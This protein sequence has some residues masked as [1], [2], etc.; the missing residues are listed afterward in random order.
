LW[1]HTKDG[2]VLVRTTEYSLPA[3]LN[4][5]IELIQP[6]TTFNR[7]KRQR[8]T[9]RFSPVPETSTSL[10]PDANITVPS[11][12][13]TVNASC[14]TTMTVSCIKQLYNAVHYVPHAMNKNGIAVTGYL[15]QFAN[16]DDLQR[17]YAAQ[18]PAAVNTSFDVVLIDGAHRIPS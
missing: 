18:V 11:Y 7:A 6:T 2:E 14:V 3:Y 5:H 1:K 13:V 12:G 15:E 16:F 8:A 4:E 17:F 10:S 9:L